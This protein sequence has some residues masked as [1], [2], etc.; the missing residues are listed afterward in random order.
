VVKKRSFFKTGQS[1]PKPVMKWAVFQIHSQ[2]RGTIFIEKVHCSRLQVTCGVWMVDEELRL[3]VLNGRSEANNDTNIEAQQQRGRTT[4]K[5][6]ATTRD[7]A[8]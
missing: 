3:R 1:G 2:Q 6:I 7:G 4:T 5:Q 8:G